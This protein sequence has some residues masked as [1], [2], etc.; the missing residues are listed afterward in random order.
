MKTERS[1]DNWKTFIELFSVRNKN[2]PTRV[3]VF[4]GAP[5]DMSDYWIE[6]G[7]PL[8]GIDVDTHDPESPSV[9]IMLGDGKGDT[10]HLTH[11]VNNARFAKIL[12]SASS[13]ADGLEIEDSE[14]RRTILQF[15][16]YAAPVQH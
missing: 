3:A 11:T 14:G 6:D 5:G 10:R 16:K 13:E 15:E 9:E 7:L 2:R 4:E 8:A 1:N 12:L